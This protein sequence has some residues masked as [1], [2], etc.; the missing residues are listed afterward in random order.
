[1]KITRQTIIFE[2]LTVHP[3]ALAI[4]ERYGMNCS[5]CM[6]VMKENLQEAALR[7]GAD[8]ETLMQDLTALEEV[9]T[10]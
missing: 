3:E 2:I 4:F 6:K 8:L 5:G 7:H 1:M 9:G 10:T